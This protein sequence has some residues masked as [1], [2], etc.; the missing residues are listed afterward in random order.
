MV[1]M[2]KPSDVKK[3]LWDTP[4]QNSERE[5]IAMNILKL[6]RAKEDKWDSFTWQDY[7]E[8]CSHR[9]TLAEERILEEFASTGY[10]SKDGDGAYHFTRKIV[11]LYMMYSE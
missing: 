2:I 8:F 4:W 10:L 3:G 1:E 11:G 7:V 5:T 6:A 9:P